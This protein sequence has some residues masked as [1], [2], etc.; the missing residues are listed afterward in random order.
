MKV[1]FLE[2]KLINAIFKKYGFIN[3][4]TY[5]N[6][7]LTINDDKKRIYKKYLCVLLAQKEFKD[8]TRKDKK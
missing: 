2:K 7:M 6:N 1:T 3:S 8:S 4:K 5:I